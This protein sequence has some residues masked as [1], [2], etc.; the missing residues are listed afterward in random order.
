MPQDRHVGDAVRPGDY[1]CDEGS[2][3]GAGVRAFVARHAQM[4]IDQGVQP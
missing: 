4:F 1:A 3:L 2:D